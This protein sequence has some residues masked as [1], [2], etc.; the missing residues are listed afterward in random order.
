M[1]SVSSLRL[2]AIAI[3]LLLLSAST[4]LGGSGVGGVFNL[5]VQNTVNKVTA[6]KGTTTAGMLRLTNDGSGPALDLRVK[7]ANTA[8]ILLDAESTGRAQYLNAD[9]LDG[10]DSTQLVHGKAVVTGSAIALGAGGISPF[11]V[12]GAS[13]TDIYWGIGYVCPGTLTQNGSYRFLANPGNGNVNLFVDQGLG[14]P[15]YLSWPSGVEL[16]RPTNAAGE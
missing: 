16:T 5:G 9:Q 13:D 1:R 11:I 12:G 14:D 4:V 8:P 3:V 10:M 2:A 7:N 6:L 15:E